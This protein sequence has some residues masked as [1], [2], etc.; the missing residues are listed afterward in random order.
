[1][2]IGTKSLLYGAHC[3]PI[4]TYYLFKAWWRLYGFPWDIRLWF[5]FALHD[6]GYW[7][8]PNMDG[9]EG[10]THPELG[11]NIMR[12]LFGIAWYRFTL[13]HSRFYAKRDGAEISQLCVSDK[14][15]TVLTPNWIYLLLVRATGEIAEYRKPPNDRYEYSYTEKLAF[16]RD[17]KDWVANT[18]KPYMAGQVPKLNAK[19]LSLNEIRVLTEYPWEMHEPIIQAL[20]NAKRHLALGPAFEQS[21]A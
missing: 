10:E 12:R 20:L 2:K 5:A 15:A 11:A 7:G 13:Y 18:L 8:K 6:I 9:D 4:H 1:M 16:D 21:E 14:L 19:A 3:W 17:D